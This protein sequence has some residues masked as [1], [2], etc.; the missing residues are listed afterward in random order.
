MTNRFATAGSTGAIW[1]WC[2]P[3]I[4]LAVLAA[5]SP[6]T[7]SPADAQARKAA[8]PARPAQPTEATAPRQ[9]GETIMAIV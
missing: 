6:L 1:R 4:A 7:T 2:P 5:L 8:P 9:A 3:A